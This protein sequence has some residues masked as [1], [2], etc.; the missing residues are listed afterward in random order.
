M[1]EH[2]DEVLLSV[3]ES[4]ATVD[5]TSSDEIAARRGTIEG[6][7]GEGEDMVVNVA[8]GDD[9]G[10]TGG[11]VGSNG[12]MEEGTES[13]KSNRDQ[14]KEVSDDLVE[15]R[16]VSLEKVEVVKEVIQEDVVGTTVAS[17]SNCDDRKSGNGSVVGD[18]KMD[19]EPASKEPE[20]GGGEIEVMES[21]QIVA[22]GDHVV[23]E[24]TQKE[25][26]VLSSSKVPESIEGL[27]VAVE[28]GLV[29]K[30]KAKDDVNNQTLL[31]DRVT[32]EDNAHVNTK[33]TENQD[34]VDQT[35]KESFQSA[36]EGAENGS[37]DPGTA[38]FKRTVESM[39]AEPPTTMKEE[40][41]VTDEKAGK[42]EDFDSTKLPESLT[43]VDEVVVEECLAG[44]DETVHKDA[45]N[46]DQKVEVDQTSKDESSQSI[47]EARTDKEPKFEDSKMVDEPQTIEGEI[48]VKDKKEDAERGLIRETM[49]KPTCS[50]QEVT[51]GNHVTDEKTVKVD[52]LNSSKIQQ[53][54]TMASLGLEDVDVVVVDE[55]SEVKN[56][57]QDS[58]SVELSLVCAD[59]QSLPT[60][61]V[62]A[63]TS[64]ADQKI[65][66]AVCNKVNEV[67]LVENQSMNDNVVTDT[68]IPGVDTDMGV[69]TS[70]VEPATVGGD[71]TNFQE[72]Q[73]LIVDASNEGN[74]IITSHIQIPDS[75]VGVAYGSHGVLPANS[76]FSYEEAHMDR[77]EDAG[78]DIDEVLGWKDEIHSLQDGDQTMDPT[79]LSNIEEQETESLE[80]NVEAE[81]WNKMSVSLQQ[82]GY[83]PRPEHEGKFSVSDLVWGQVESHLWPGQIFDPSDASEKAMMHH[84]KGCL[85]VAYFG[86]RTF[87]WNDSTVLKPFREYFSQ[88]D[89]HMNSEAFNMAV[90]CALV[91]VSR[92]VE[93]GLTCSCIPHDI[94]D[95]IKRQIVENSG[96]KQESSRRQGLDKSASVN[97][98]EPD[99]LVDYVRILAK[100]PY[101]ESDKMELTMAMAQL[102]SYG[103]FK[104]YRQL[105]EFQSC[106]AL[107]EAE[108]VVKDEVCFEDGSKK[109][110]ALDSISDGLEKR[111][112]LHTEAVEA[113]PSFEVGAI[114]QKVASQPAGAPLKDE[115]ADDI[116]GRTVSVQSPGP[117]LMG[118]QENMLSQ[119]HFAARDPL[120]GYSF[121]NTII[122]FF[123]NHRAAVL[124]KS[125][126]N[127][128]G[129]ARKR[130]TSNNN[131]PDEFEFDDVNDSYWTDRMIQN[132]PEEQVLQENPARVA[133]HQIV[134]YEQEKPP[135]KPARRSNK[136]RFFSSNHEIE[137][138]EQSELI[139]RRQLNLATEVLMKFA[140]GIYFPSEIH[141]NKMFR[142]F[143]P[144]MESETE[145][146]RQSGR[147]RVVFKKC[148]DAEVAHSSAG[149]F[150][151]FG[152]ISV[153]YEL[154]YTPLISY[155]PLPLPVA[156]D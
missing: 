125:R 101:N 130:K 134:A 15:S 44:K 108:E 7:F 65:E 86:D 154:N 41:C 55:G 92:R 89:R 102:S 12:V 145:V 140:S 26:E 109:R 6:I 14:V 121:M 135:V 107:L 138:N 123:R 47:I 16:G 117:T 39:N 93:L 5:S 120:K 27:V 36:I 129:E 20:A 33:N 124:S 133:E 148:S 144:L 75:T 17:G 131:E 30:D 70:K 48:A 71:L 57:A 152:S 22:H 100:F 150:N 153:N 61:A 69:Q 139:A 119:L 59:N 23:E 42:D 38:D 9:H 13:Q 141:L 90:H 80:H 37:Q 28:E 58:V 66:V 45:E 46:L 25:T 85:L 63:G 149:K 24:K 113:K 136:K 60:D 74:E 110:K 95:N 146:D 127:M 118:H 142:R 105:A 114:I 1:K 96:I 34:G 126:L 8:S 53:S 115:P 62:D 151:I 43:R 76:E 50:A 56:E 94:Y 31:T 98:F 19:S 88:V 32:G 111:P 78:M 112:T 81:H 3:K 77:G 155:K 137:A 103:R 35:N 116:A 54:L 87:A 91:E 51:D 156:Q 83:F 132:L 128:S 11:E 68:S 73:G 84:K 21:V 79:N 106:A 82:S 72:D 2:T 143:G 52:V 99:K 18:C 122:P 67:I 10:V 49:D 64:E 40:G 104:G 29:V 4:S 97:S 147:A